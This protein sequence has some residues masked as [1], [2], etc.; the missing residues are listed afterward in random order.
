MV[1]FLQVSTSEDLLIWVQAGLVL[2]IIQERHPFRWGLR[3]LVHLKVI[4]QEPV[5][6]FLDPK[7]INPQLAF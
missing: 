1:L 5:Q 4:F 6:L 2:V 3:E 7:F